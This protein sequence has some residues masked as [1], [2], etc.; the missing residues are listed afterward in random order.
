MWNMYKKINKKKQFPMMS[1]LWAATAIQF[2]EAKIFLLERRCMI[3]FL[4][5][6]CAF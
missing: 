1:L 5:S 3:C 2:Y 6:V 4:N